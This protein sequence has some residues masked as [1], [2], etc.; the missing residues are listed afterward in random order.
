MATKY[1]LAIAFLCVAGL[2]TSAASAFAQHGHSS[3]GHASG[4]SPAAH[5]G[6]GHAQSASTHHSGGGHPGGGHPGVHVGAYVQPFYGGYYPGIFGGAYPWYDTYT[7][8]RNSYYYNPSA[9]YY[10]PPVLDFFAPAVGQYS[11]PLNY[12]PPDPSAVPG[13][14]VAQ[15]RVILPDPQ[16]RVWFDGKAT[17]QTGTDRLF[18]T[19]ELAD[20]STYNYQLRAAWTTREGREITQERTVAVT[21]GRT[22]V[23]DFAR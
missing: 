12:G 6:T 5:P 14:A 13:V 9:G 21:P 22:T 3:A 23:I 2:L 16:A 19:P 11:R 18:D 17:S 20:G 10:P 15:I 7:N 1:R 4:H 8:P